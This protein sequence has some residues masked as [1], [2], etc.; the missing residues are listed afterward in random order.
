MKK[1]SKKNWKVE[2]DGT[3]IVID[4]QVVIT[5]TA[6]DGSSLDERK[7][8]ARLIA[9][10]PDLFTACKAAYVTLIDDEHYQTF[11]TLIRTLEEAI[12]KAS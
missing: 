6:P 8:N 11:K 2:S 5:D 4:G 10:A 9:A 12:N 1:T 3:S 7:A